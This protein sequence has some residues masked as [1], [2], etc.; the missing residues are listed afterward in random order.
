[1]IAE[2][3]LGFTIPGTSINS[4]ST[5]SL[6][7]MLAFLVGSY[8]AAKE[9][10]RKNL[11]SKAVETHVFLSVIG[12]IIGAKIGF[13][14]E[15]WERIWI[16]DPEGFWTTLKYVLFYFHGMGEKYPGIAV[17][18]WESLFSRGGL[19]FYGGVFGAALFIYIHI[20]I[21]KL[22]TWTYGDIYS[23]ML[24]IGYGIGRM[25]CLISGDGCYG[26]ASNVDIP[27]LTMVYGP[28]SVMSTMGV[29]VWNT[30][31]MEA[32]LSWILFAW[33]WFKGR[34]MNFKPGFMTALLMI[35]N[36]IARFLVEFLRLNDAVIP[37]LPHPSY[38][39]QDLIHHNFWP[40]NPPAYY[41][42]NWHWYGFTQS[43]IVGIVIAI[44]GLIW[45]WRGKL[46]QRETTA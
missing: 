3:P 2:I 28:K 44:A 18:L 29:R 21:K 38:N 26:Y 46:Y 11:D 5:F 41:F 39:G 10:M 1:M 25:G 45:L 35:Y 20:K 22:D 31:L 4:I 9:A 15:V 23:M 34:H 24:A 14:F 7:M 40:G 27:L 16:P 8:L 12:T 17:G 37:I 13:V 36:G 30:P 33:M 32:V 6:M 43:Q 42:E 19:V